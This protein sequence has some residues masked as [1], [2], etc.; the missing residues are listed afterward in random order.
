MGRKYKNY[1]DD[2]KN[3]RVQDKFIEHIIH[4][5]FFTVVLSIEALYKKCK[6]I[7]FHLKNLLRRRR[8]SD[9]LKKYTRYKES[10]NSMIH[11]HAH[12]QNLHD[13]I[14]DTMNHL[15]SDEEKKLVFGMKDSKQIF[16]EKSKQI[17]TSVTDYTKSMKSRYF[18]YKP[19]TGFNKNHTAAMLTLFILKKYKDNK[20]IFNLSIN[21]EVK[22]IFVETHSSGYKKFINETF[23]KFYSNEFKQKV[24]ITS[25]DIQSLKPHIIKIIHTIEKLERKQIKYTFGQS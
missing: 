21:P 2:I 20:S 13:R 16:M 17:I 7:L 18:K 22:K 14:H 12:I 11:N 1:F 4:L 10:V 3:K 24:S 8:L 15:F 19:F 5:L 9:V 25:L 6:D 23:N